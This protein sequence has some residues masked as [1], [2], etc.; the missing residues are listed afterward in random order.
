[1]TEV[2]IWLGFILLTIVI[3][4]LIYCGKDIRRMER[5][6]FGEVLQEKISERWQKMW[7]P[8]AEGLPKKKNVHYMVTLKLRVEYD[9]PVFYTEW[10]LYSETGMWTDSHGYDLT[11][12]VIAWMPLPEPY[13]EEKKYG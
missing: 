13:K 10:L 9:E 3:E 1:M 5:K 7:H 8:V 6:H 4:F 2:L 12:D 11:E